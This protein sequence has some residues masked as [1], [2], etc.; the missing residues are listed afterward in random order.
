MEVKRLKAFAL[1]AL[2]AGASF[3]AVVFILVCTSIIQRFQVYPRDGEGGFAL[4][5]IEL[6]VGFLTA[7]VVGLICLHHFSGGHASSTGHRMANRNGRT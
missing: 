1:S 5:L 3:F 4:F 2:T 7:S 6:V